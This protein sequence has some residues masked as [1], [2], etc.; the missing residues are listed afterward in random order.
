M[1]TLSSVT[2][3]MMAAL[4]VAIAM[5]AAGGLAELDIRNSLLAVATRSS[6]ARKF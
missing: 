4:S 6:T 1:S 2:I 3:A 5:L